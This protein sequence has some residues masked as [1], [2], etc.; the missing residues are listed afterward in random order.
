[1]I[2]CHCCIKMAFKTQII[3]WGNLFVENKNE[4]NK[5]NLKDLMYTVFTR[6]Y[7]LMI[8]LIVCVLAAVI[9]SNFIATPLY[10][11]T[12]KLYIMNKQSENISSSDLSVSIYLARDY[13]KLIVDKAI[14][15]EVSD[16]L[17]NK[18]SYSQLKSAITVV[19]PE[20]TRFLEITVKTHDAADSKR[21]VDL[22]CEVSQEKTIELLG[23]DRIVI[24]RGGNIS[25][26]PSSPNISGNIM[27]SIFAAVIVFAGIVLLYCFLSDKI[28]EPEDVEEYLDMRV[29][30]NIPY[31][32]NKKKAKFK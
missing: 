30:G 15:D 28:N 24:I 13:E 26:V 9:Y 3:Y 31:N 32:Q 21:I 11:S 6:W 12:G 5:L 18:Y 22:L 2:E 1:M 14:L 19:N 7:I 20:D 8:L 4:Y 17:D 27:K 10:D 23:I 25:S 29:L 16:E